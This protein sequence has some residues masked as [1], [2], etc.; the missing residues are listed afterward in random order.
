MT[1]VAT[2]M[3]WGEYERCT[4]DSLRTGN[5]ITVPAPP[6]SVNPKK[7]ARTILVDEWLWP[8]VL[9]AVPCPIT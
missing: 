7:K 2:G 8:W 9:Q 3:R 4:R 1:L 5:K 6:G